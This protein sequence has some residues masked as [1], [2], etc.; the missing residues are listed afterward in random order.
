[1]NINIY[2]DPGTLGVVAAAG[3]VL[4][5]PLWAAIWYPL[6]RHDR[7]ADRRA[8]TQ[9]VAGYGRAPVSPLDPSLDIPLAEPAQAAGPTVAE[10]ADDLTV[11][12][13]TDRWGTVRRRM[14][15]YLSTLRPD[16]H[17]GWDE[18]GALDELREA[19]GPEPAGPRHRR[20]S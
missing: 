9:A 7:L 19:A 5:M 6:G 12:Q 4:S 10:M 16:A 17:R 1:M 14:A 8:E 15:D 18:P 20:V 11:V 3:A 2:A 13:A